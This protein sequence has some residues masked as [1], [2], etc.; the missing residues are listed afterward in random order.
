MIIKTYWFHLTSAVIWW[1]RWWFV[2][3]I[4]KKF[5]MRYLSIGRSSPSTAPSSTACNTIQLCFFITYCCILSSIRNFN[6]RTL[7]CFFVFFP[8]Q[9]WVTLTVLNKSGTGFFPKLCSS[10]PLMHPSKKAGLQ[11]D[12]CWYWQVDKKYHNLLQNLRRWRCYAT[13][14][15]TCHRRKWRCMWVKYTTLDKLFLELV[16]ISELQPTVACAPFCLRKY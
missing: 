14:V 11:K 13:V 8:S 5:L 3:I 6:N 12:N 10:W 1:H 4:L 16:N 2:K 9:M 15:V 7:F